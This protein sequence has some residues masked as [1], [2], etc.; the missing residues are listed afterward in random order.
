MSGNT[1]KAEEGAK[2]GGKGMLIGILA[3]VL[4]G[5]GGAGWF[6]LKPKPDPDA[7]I[8]ALYAPSAEPIFVSLDPFTVNL[9][10]EEDE[11]MAQVT[12]VLQMLNK[13]AEDMLKK[14]MPVVRNELLLLVSAQESK[15]IRSLKGKERLAEDLA[16]R[17]AFALGWEKPEEKRDDKTEEGRKKRPGAAAAIPE[18]RPVVAVH[19]NQLLV[20]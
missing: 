20:Q 3:L 1:E 4:A 2:K 17:T 6:F 15:Q 12:I 16:D 7:E 14:N 19:F 10:D 5:G 11:A 9:A 18:P 8:K 13:R